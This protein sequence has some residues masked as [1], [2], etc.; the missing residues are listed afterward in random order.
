MV[1]RWSIGEAWRPIGNTVYGTKQQTTHVVSAYRTKRSSTHRS[2][3]HQAVRGEVILLRSENQMLVQDN[4][5]MIEVSIPSLKREVD[6]S[7]KSTKVSA[8]Y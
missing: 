2:G 5:P 4:F 1:C 3:C 6:E 8:I 7:G